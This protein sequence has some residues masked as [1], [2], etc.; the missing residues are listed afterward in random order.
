MDVAILGARQKS[1]FGAG[2]S[3]NLIIPTPTEF[4]VDASSMAKGGCDQVSAASERA[5]SAGESKFHKMHQLPRAA[6]SSRPT[7]ASDKGTGDRLGSQLPPHRP[8]SAS[9]ASK[10]GVATEKAPEAQ[11]TERP[12]A[13]VVLRKCEDVHVRTG[14]FQKIEESA[15]GAHRRLLRDPNDL[16]TCASFTDWKQLK[17]NRFDFEAL[18]G[19]VGRL[20]HNWMH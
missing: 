13:V 5:S 14:G 17:M 11:L 15:H 10:L 1:D 8:V 7:S 3:F 16:S 18:G 9:S 4:T 20:V 12:A 19:R 2:K 6:G